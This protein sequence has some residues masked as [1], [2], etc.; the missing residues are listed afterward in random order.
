[1]DNQESKAAALYPV[2][3]KQADRIRTPGGHKL[4]DLTLEN[5]LAGKLTARDIGISPGALQLQGEVAR[6]VGRSWLAD[7]FDR[8]A[9]L[10]QYRAADRR[11]R[12]GL[13]AERPVPKE[14]LTLGPTGASVVR[15]ED[16][17]LA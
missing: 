12:R 4:S 5:V 10:A 15:K 6:A 17:Q 16:V 2:S 1:M 7:A 3:E 13:C 9:E 8:G 14:V 11:G